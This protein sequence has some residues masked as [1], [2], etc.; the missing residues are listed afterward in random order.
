ML[1]LLFN[2]RISSFLALS[3]ISSL[4][5]I[6]GAVIIHQ[7]NKFKALQMERPLWYSQIS[8]SATNE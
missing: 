6:L 1:S 4:A 8:T 3:I 2:R 7:S 5:F